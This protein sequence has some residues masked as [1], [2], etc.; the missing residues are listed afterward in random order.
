MYCHSLLYFAQSRCFNFW[1]HYWPMGSSLEF[2]EFMQERDLK[3]C[4]S[5]GNYNSAHSASSKQMADAGGGNSI[6]PCHM[7]PQHAEHA[8]WIWPISARRTSLSHTVQV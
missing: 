3:Q 5:S 7:M 4:I 1:C 2:R 6:Q 8:Y